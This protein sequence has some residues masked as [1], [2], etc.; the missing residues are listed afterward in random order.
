M[1]KITIV[2]VTY[3]CKNVVEETIQSVLSQDYPNIEYIIVD[4]AST[5]GTL[6]VINKY[7]I[8]K[9]LSE[10]DKGVYDAMNKAVKLASGTWINFM[11]AGD[12]FV[13]KVVIRNVFQST[14]EDAGV[15]FGD[16]LSVNGTHERVVR[17]NPKNWK[18]RI[19]PSCHQSI[20]VKRKVLLD[21][22]FN[23][24]YK[25]SAD[26]D[27]FKR[28]HK[29]NVLFKYVPII[30]ARYNCAE[31]ISQNPRKYYKELCEIAFSKYFGTIAFGV[32]YLRFF[33]GSCLRYLNLRNK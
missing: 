16:T 17:Y 18:H 31:G 15:V 13:S 1:D 28:M 27:S 2:T 21:T 7:K 32:F 8:S 20:F 11:N 5:D 9:V 26:V 24:K 4:G 3:N 19:M 12:T 22:P 30:V 33:I 29:N 10:S 23:L 6:D 14:Y 25:I